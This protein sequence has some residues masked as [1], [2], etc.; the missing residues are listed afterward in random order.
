MAISPCRAVCMDRFTST[1]FG[2]NETL[3]A[4]SRMQQILGEGSI[5]VCTL[6]NHTITFMV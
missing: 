3:S 5:S 4:T 1:K 6:R 2:K